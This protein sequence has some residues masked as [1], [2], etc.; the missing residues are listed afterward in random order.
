[1]YDVDGDR[2]ASYNAIKHPRPC[3]VRSEDELDGMILLQA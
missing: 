2:V 3:V 1:M